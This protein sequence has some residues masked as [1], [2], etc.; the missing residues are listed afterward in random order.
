MQR[1][2]PTQHTHYSTS[3][4]AKGDVRYAC[5]KFAVRHAY[6]MEII[7]RDYAYTL[8]FIFACINISLNSM[9]Y[10]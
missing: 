4:I 6:E 3:Q 5:C 10:K 1:N 8:R 7:I 2:S 9:F